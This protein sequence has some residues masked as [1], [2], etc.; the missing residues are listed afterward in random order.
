MSRSTHSFL[1]DC[2][3]TNNVRTLPDSLNQTDKLQDQFETTQG[4]YSYKPTQRQQPNMPA[5][6]ANSAYSINVPAA[7]RTLPFELDP[8]KRFKSEF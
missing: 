5:N 6:A 2:S 7:A 3:R 8:A 1:H 4:T